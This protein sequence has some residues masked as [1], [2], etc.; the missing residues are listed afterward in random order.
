MVPAVL[1]WGGRA[2]FVLARG[3]KVGV[4]LVVLL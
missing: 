2:I 3:E 1:L 4:L